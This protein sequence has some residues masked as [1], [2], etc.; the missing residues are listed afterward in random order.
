MGRGRL[1]KNDMLARVY[2]L[3]NKLYN[4]KHPCHGWEWHEGRHSALDE[5]LDILNEYSH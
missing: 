1:D 2:K 4:S 3:K 5:I